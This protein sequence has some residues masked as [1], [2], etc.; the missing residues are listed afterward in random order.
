MFHHGDVETSEFPYER[1]QLAIARARETEGVSESG[2]WRTA[3][4][5]SAAAITEALFE[6]ASSV[7]AVDAEDLSYRLS[8][9][10]DIANALEKI[11]KAMPDAD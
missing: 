9:L 1:A 6:I 2:L 8:S 3:V 11:A 5:E 4:I 7:A 10:A